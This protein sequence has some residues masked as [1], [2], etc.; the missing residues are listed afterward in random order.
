MNIKELNKYLKTE[1]RDKN[2]RVSRPWELLKLKYLNRI[3]V[4]SYEMTYL[5]MEQ[6]GEW[7][8]QIEERGVVNKSESFQTEKEACIFFKGLFKQKEQKNGLPNGWTETKISDNAY[9]T[10]IPQ[11]QKDNWIKE[12]REKD[13]VEQL[14][15]KNGFHD[16]PNGRQGTIYFVDNG[17][18]CELYYEISGAKEYD[19]LIWFD[20]LNKWFLPKVETIS[21]IDKQKI[22]NEL[23]NWLDSKNIRAEL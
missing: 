15:K 5:I 3:E 22:K 6:G 14:I 18:I 11:E 23:Q 1:L 13:K 12:R 9:L 16:K 4:S 19:I 8:I 21:P 17:K 20:H 2:Y 10:E 7:K